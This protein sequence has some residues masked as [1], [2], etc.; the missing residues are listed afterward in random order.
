[1]F[2]FNI[3]A[4]TMWLLRGLAWNHLRGGKVQN[5]PLIL[6]V[7]D[8]VLIQTLVEE[9]LQEGGFETAIAPSAEEAVTLIKGRVRNYRALVT[10]INLKGR[11]TGWEVARHARQIVPEFPIVYMTGAAARDWT[12]QGVPNSILLVKPFVPAQLVTAVSQ[13]LIVG[14][15]N[16]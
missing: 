5:I 15:P 8:D 6:I 10:D 7:E 12:S 4:G 1:M 3:Y 16:G 9:A 2:T 14:T 13:L 11:M